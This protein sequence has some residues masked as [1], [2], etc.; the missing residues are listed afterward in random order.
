MTKLIWLEKFIVDPNY[1]FKW[2]NFGIPVPT[3]YNTKIDEF[4]KNNNVLSW[5]TTERYIICEV[6]DEIQS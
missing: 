3:I 1:K 5:K 6:K 4:F 2:Y